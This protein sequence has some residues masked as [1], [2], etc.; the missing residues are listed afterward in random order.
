MSNQNLNF[1]HFHNEIFH[2][3]KEYSRGS[4]ISEKRGVGG[5]IVL[6]YLLVDI[7]LFWYDSSKYDYLSETIVDIRDA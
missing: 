2:M 4:K 6:V 3:N 7:Y 1:L 5:E